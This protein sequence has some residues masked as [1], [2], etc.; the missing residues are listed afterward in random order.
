M[1]LEDSIEKIKGV[2]PK[3][4]QVLKK[5]KIEKVED[6][7]NYFPR[8]YEDM[9]Q[10]KNLNQV[11]DGEKAA[12]KLK[13]YEEPRFLYKNRLKMMTV[14]MTDGKD[15]A[16]VTFFNS[17]FLKPQFQI[18]REF[19][20]YG[21]I[22][23]FRGSYQISMP[24]YEPLNKKNKIGKIVPYYPLT[25]EI[26]NNELIKLTD[27]VLKELNFENIIPENLIE[28]YKLLERDKVIRQLHRP[29]DEN[30]FDLARKTYA[31]EEFL[32]YLTGL[33]SLKK[34]KEEITR[35]AFKNFDLEELYKKIPFELTNSQK[36]VVEESIEDLSQK[37]P[38]SRLIQ[39]DVGSGKTIVAMILM[40]LAFINGCQSALMAPTEI[41]A[42]QH[43]ENFKN[44]LGD[45]GVNISLLTGSDTAK[46]RQESLQ[47][48]KEGTINMVV[49]THALF[50]ENVEFKNLGLTVI[51]EQHRFGV[52]QRKKLA[53]KGINTL[54]MTATPIPRTLAL[55]IYNDLDIS[56]IDT[57]PEGRQKIETFTIGSQ[58]LIKSLE[59]IKTELLKN[60][61]AYVVCPMI[62]ENENLDLSSVNKVYREIVKYYKDYKVGLLHG[63]MKAEEKEKVMEDFA[64]NKINILVSTTVVEVG[65]NVKNATVILIVNAE[66]F[67]LSQL[68]QLRGR[69]GR[70]KDKGYCILYNKS[71]SDIA[72]E[73]MKVLNSSTDGFYIAKQDL[74]LRGT[75][76]IFG[77]RQSGIPEFKFADPLN[78]KVILEKVLDESSKILRE[79]PQLKSEKNKNLKRA[80]DKLLSAKAN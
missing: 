56:T 28:K 54:I 74:L 75:G 18:N 24:I 43:Y 19:Y 64:K 30:L 9:S 31:F 20:L 57:M 73:R 26:S 52:E 78:D 1:K 70:G 32:V 27:L 50:Y 68:H 22:K 69:V 35:E 14:P 39:G 11:F 15:R 10:I 66:R 72:L 8:S 38:M 36:K 53:E 25:K 76:D 23:K 77:L 6:L 59:F 65:V 4:A 40:Y 80:I 17:N 67:G 42:K 5:L 63:Q 12:L 45:L 16:D 33:M 21:K 51:D 41:L 13:V 37:R 79:D 2:G 3:K 58:G 60:H 44:I 49:G 7:A 46:K 61:Q 71:S 47:G 34:E 48:L 55:T 29:S 62:D